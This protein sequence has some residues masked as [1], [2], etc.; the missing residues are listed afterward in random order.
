MSGTIFLSLIR[1]IK[2]YDRVNTGRMLF[3]LFI[4]TKNGGS[5]EKIFQI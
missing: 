2:A 5:H 1:D 4:R 3:F